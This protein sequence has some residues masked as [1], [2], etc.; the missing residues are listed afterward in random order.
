VPLA[1]IILLDPGLGRFVEPGQGEVSIVSASFTKR[2]FLTLRTI[3]WRPRLC[4]R[5]L[6]VLATIFQE[7]DSSPH[8]IGYNERRNSITSGR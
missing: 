7:A 6:P 2:H 8:K 5:R 4:G 3:T 1:V